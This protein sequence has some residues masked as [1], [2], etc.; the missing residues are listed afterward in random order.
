MRSGRPPV[1][2]IW[3]ATSRSE[4]RVVAALTV[5]HRARWARA[6]ELLRGTEASRLRVALRRRSGLA[7]LTFGSCYIAAGFRGKGV[8]AGHSRRPRED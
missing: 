7:P 3:S 2:Q 5:N 8:P 4:V 1:W 6:W